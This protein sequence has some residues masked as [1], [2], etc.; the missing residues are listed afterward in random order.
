PYLTAK[1][2]PDAPEWVDPIKDVNAKIAAVRAGFLSRAEV[3]SG[4]GYDVE[5]VD[6]E[7]AADLARANR[8]GLALSTDARPAAPAT[9][10]T[11]DNEEAGHDQS[12]E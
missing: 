7:I 5:E 1:W 9:S 11:P 3:V 8:L 10:D 6:A 12:D 2:I 4:L